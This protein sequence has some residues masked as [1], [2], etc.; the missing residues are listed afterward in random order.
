MA[1]DVKLMSDDLLTLYLNNIWRPFCTLTGF[2][3]FPDVNNAPNTLRKEVSL[4][5]SI[6]LAPSMK[7]DEAE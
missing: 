6:R 1:K 7:G 4:K 5:M 3:G 2:D